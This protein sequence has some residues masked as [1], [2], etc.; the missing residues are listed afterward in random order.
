MKLIPTYDAVQN[1]TPEQIMDA[2][3]KD[4]GEILLYFMLVSLNNIKNPKDRFEFD[5][6]NHRRCSDETANS[7]CGRFSHEEPF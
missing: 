3:Q 4:K 6:D 1:I 7:G 5:E 2:W